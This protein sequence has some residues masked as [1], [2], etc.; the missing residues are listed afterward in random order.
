MRIHTRLLF[1]A[2]LAFNVTVFSVHGQIV[3]GTIVGSVHDPSGAALTQT[4][5]VLRA[6]DTNQTRES[7]RSPSPPCLP[8]V[9]GYLS[10]IQASSRP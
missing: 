1:L 9:I 7:A 8:A 6:I 3:S 10:S 4:H 2:A 5:V